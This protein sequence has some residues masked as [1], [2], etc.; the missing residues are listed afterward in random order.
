MVG[1]LLHLGAT[2]ICPHGGQVS[3]ITNNTRVFVEGQPVV[4][5]NDLFPIAG[6]P[7]TILVSPHPCIEIKWLTPATRV[8]V[9]HQPVILK[10]SVGIC[11]SA[12]Q[13]PQ[14]S[15]IVIMSQMRVK[16]V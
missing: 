12:D 16:G 10:N 3:S 7:F 2:I 15:P 4:T 9:N 8:F 5:Q 1:F 13:T 14:G 11:K 6:C